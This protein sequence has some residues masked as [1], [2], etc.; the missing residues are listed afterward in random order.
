MTSTD[1]R[2]GIGHLYRAP[3][4]PAAVDVPALLVL[5]VEGS[6]APDPAANP[7]WGDAIGALSAV[8]YGLRAQAKAAGLAPWT[9]MPLEALWWADDWSAYLDGRRD[10]WRWTALIVQPGFATA[11]RVAEAVAAARR[12]GNASDA[13]GLVRLKTLDEGACWHVLHCGPYADEAPTVA[14]LHASIGDRGLR[15]AHHEIYLSDP[16]RV[17]P[18]RM[19]TIIRQPVGRGAG[20][21]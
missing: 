5:A 14:A 3:G 6:G 18:E 12:R 13:L 17:A 10:E 15:G 20:V 7:A 21:G 8:S 1:P 19:R 2:T 11:E 9:V 16:R 4:T